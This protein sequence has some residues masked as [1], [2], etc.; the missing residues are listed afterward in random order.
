MNT[1]TVKRSD[2]SPWKMVSG[3]E[4]MHPVVIDNGVVKIWTAIGWTNDRQ[5]TPSD[6]ATY[7]VVI[8]D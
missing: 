5:A 3:M 8:E 4:D 1:P 7:P 6:I 2:L